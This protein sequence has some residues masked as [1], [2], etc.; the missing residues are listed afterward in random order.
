[1]A[2]QSIFET[3]PKLVKTLE[4]EKTES[5]SQESR[6]NGWTKCI[7]VEKL[8][9]QGY[10]VCINVYGNTDKGEYKSVTRKLYSDTNPLDPNKDEDPV[11]KVVN[12]LT[13]KTQL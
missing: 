5:W 7:N 10:L 4:K 12:N 9:N 1:M 6:V 11:D 2:K 8:F 3:D 13:S